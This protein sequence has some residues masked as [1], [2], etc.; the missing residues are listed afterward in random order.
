MIPMVVIHYPRAEELPSLY[1]AWWVM[2]GEED[3]LTGRVELVEA[4][5]PQSLTHSCRCT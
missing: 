5:E 2:H 4:F 3:A 1:H